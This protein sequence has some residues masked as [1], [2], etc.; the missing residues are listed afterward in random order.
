MK[1]RI[2]LTEKNCTLTPI[3]TVA[4][5]NKSDA[6]Y[7]SEASTTVPE[8][9]EAGTVEAFPTVPVSEEAG[10][11][12]EEAGTVGAEEE[13]TVPELGLRLAAAELEAYASSRY[14]HPVTDVTVTVPDGDI[15]VVEAWVGT[16]VATATPP[17]DILLKRITS[18]VMGAINRYF[19]DAARAGLFTRPL[20]VACAL[21]LK[22]GKYAA[23]GT[24]RLLTPADRAPLVVIRE[25]QFGGTTLRT[26]VELMNTPQTLT[27]DIPAFEVAAELAANITHLDIIATRQC[28]VLAG[29]ESV[30]GIRSYALYGES[31]RIWHYRRLEADVVAEA[32]ENDRSFRVIA[33]VPIAEA[34]PGKTGIRLPLGRKNLD[35]WE[36]FPK[37]D[38]DSA[39]GKDPDQ[40]DEPEVPHTHVMLAT[41]PLDLGLPER[42]KRV[43]GVTLRGIFERGA[44]DIDMRLYASHHRE[45]WHRLATSR[46]PH[47]RFLRAVRCRWLRVE[48]RLRR[49]A[50][51]DALTF[52]VADH[53]D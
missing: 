32:A 49:E 31:V 9:K 16:G 18:A 46:G 20:R 24:P 41:G 40:P 4:E 12:A 23:V 50:K 5:A 19:T 43:R 42:E 38:I 21:R 44:D 3:P 25:L 39:G 37:A 22:D 36:S 47:I 51:V 6:T 29:D 26:H 13:P 27:A 7:L 48:A 35:D 1:I 2:E 8:A 34:T 14:T 28:D 45:R 10:R 52:S 17:S 11:A 33:S 53:R 15:P 30:E